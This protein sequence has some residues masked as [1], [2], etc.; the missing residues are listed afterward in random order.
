[1]IYML[2]I[3]LLSF[4]NFMNLISSGRIVGNIIHNKFNDAA[5]KINNNF[6][7][8]EPMNFLDP[9]Q[10]ITNKHNLIYNEKERDLFLEDNNFIKNKKSKYLSK[11]IYI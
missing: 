4:I 1:M 8:N 2:F 5:F 10:I 6:C 11:I 7:I 9:Q 3:F